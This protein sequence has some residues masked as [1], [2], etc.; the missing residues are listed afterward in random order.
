VRPSVFLLAVLAPNALVGCSG[1][2][3]TGECMGAV[4]AAIVGGSPEDGASPDDGI[5][6][7]WVAVPVAGRRLS[8]LCT[9]SRTRSGKALTA[10]HCIGDAVQ[11][12]AWIGFG[13]QAHGV[14]DGCAPTGADVLTVRGHTPHPTLDIDVLDFDD[15]DSAGPVLSVAD[16]PPGLGAPVE[17][18]GYG[19]SENGTYGAKRTARS[20]VAALDGPFVT[21]DSGGRTG[22]CVG[23]SG[24]PLLLGGAATGPTVAGVLS[25]GSPDCRGSDVYV[26]GGVRAW[27]AAIGA[28]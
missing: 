24:G 12:Q 6:Y 28:L 22:A 11:W 16:R 19:M 5:G 7:L 20:S 3:S 4:Q 21:V 15:N 23:D 8:R 2:S 14:P 10:A 26:S 17:L 9:V 18:V 1:D 25:Q 27:L 13:P